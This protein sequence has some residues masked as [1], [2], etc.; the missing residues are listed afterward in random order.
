MTFTAKNRFNITAFAIAAT[1]TFA[2]NGTMLAGF[3]QLASAGEGSN[4]DITRSA[5]T[6]VTPNTVTLERV[7]I[8]TRRA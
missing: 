5:K 8:T 2:L 3:N 1:A 4:S 6:E 7:V